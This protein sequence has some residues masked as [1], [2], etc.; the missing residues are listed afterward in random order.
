M[1]VNIIKHLTADHVVC[2]VPYIVQINY[3]VVFLKHSF[4]SNQYELFTLA[5]M[6]NILFD[7]QLFLIITRTS[8]AKAHEICVYLI[9]EIAARFEA[10]D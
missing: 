2:L 10:K 9:F 5:R 3:F 4:C 7:F 6:C 1:T 8:I